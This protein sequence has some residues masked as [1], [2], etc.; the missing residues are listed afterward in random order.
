MKDT[1]CLSTGAGERGSM[2]RAPAHKG[3][4]TSS[5]QLDALTNAAM[6]RYILGDDRA[7]DDLYRL[8]APRLLG[9]CCRLAGPVD[10]E[11]ICQETFIKICRARNTCGLEGNV[12]TW[13]FTIARRTFLD[14]V[15]H[16]RRR[17]EVS[18]AQAE[19]A[20]SA[21]ASTSCPEFAID[22][23]RFDQELERQ[24]GSLSENLRSAYLLVK[25]TG[26]SCA[27]AGAE[28]DSSVNAVKQRVHRASE[29]LSEGMLQWAS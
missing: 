14:R 18:S 9:M 5:S 19:L 24:I 27:Q 25:R 6:E 4:R 3:Q 8:L 22:R 21:P 16:R 29:E 17:P 11:D 13:A 23:R 7:F 28:L 15:R 12:A 1:A 20:M 2:D 26:L 10:A